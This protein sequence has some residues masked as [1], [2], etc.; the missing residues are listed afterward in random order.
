MGIGWGEEENF[1]FFEVCCYCFYLVVGN[2]FEKKSREGGFLVFEI[3][4]IF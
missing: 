1:D 2:G 3:Y 4:L